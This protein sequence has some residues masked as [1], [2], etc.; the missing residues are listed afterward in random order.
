MLAKSYTREYSSWKSMRN[1]CNNTNAI[2]YHL[3]GGRGITVDPRWDDFNSFYNDMGPRPVGASLDRIDV[4]GNYTPAN[5]RWATQTTQVRNSGNSKLTFK[6]AM[7]IRY[8][9]EFYKDI[10]P[11][12]GVAEHTVSEIKNGNIWKATTIPQ[13]VAECH[14]KFG[15][16]QH[17]IPKLLDENTAK[18]RHMLMAEETAEFLCA[19]NAQNLID[20]VDAC[21]DL[22]YVAAGALLVM[23]LSTEQIDLC[24]EEVHRANMQKVKCETAAES[25]RGNSV[26]LRKPEGW[27]S[28]ETRIHKIL[29]G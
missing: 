27:V 22:L 26:D 16:P 13:M 11:K 2:G 7:E 4:N 25:K 15:I 29:F 5:C 19:S 17:N 14:A 8:T 24:F 9:R 1:R 3:Y 6:Q 21:L 12:Y 10:A 18:F 23:G 20:Q 28:P